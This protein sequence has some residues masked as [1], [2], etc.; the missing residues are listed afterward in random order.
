MNQAEQAVPFVQ[1]IFHP[2]DFS[3]A[4]QL[5]FAHALKR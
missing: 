2:S 3:Q 5:A 4:R 1:S